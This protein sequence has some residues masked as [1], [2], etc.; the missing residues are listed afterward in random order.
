[1][2]TPEG[3]GPSHNPADP[4]AWG[5]QPPGGWGRPQEKAAEPADDERTQAVDPRAWQR[6]QP[7]G[8]ERTQAVDQRAWQ[9]G[10]AAQQAPQA[11]PQQPYGQ[12]GW[13][14]P[15]QQYAGQQPYGA[16]Q[17]EGPQPTQQYPGAQQA[18][19]QQ[20]APPGQQWGG[21]QPDAQQWGQGYPPL[22]EAPATSGRSKLPFILGGVGVLVVAAV[23][24]LGF[25]TPGFFVSKVFDTAAVQSGVQKILTDSYGVQG[26]TAVTCG[27]DIAVTA[28]ASFTCDATIDGQHVKVPVRITSS[29]GDYQVGRPA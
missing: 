20:A 12:Q 1:M 22:P 17:Y 6:P 26:V 9:Q 10:A 24:V 18:W 16:P 21:Q 13:G 15:P 5:Q 11:T 19:G 2:T 23:L 3:P 25:V 4:P 28:G 7:A 14:P 29:S 27:Q 8:D